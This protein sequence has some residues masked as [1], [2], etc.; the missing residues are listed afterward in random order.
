MCFTN[1][2]KFPEKGFAQLYIFWPLSWEDE[3][4][5]MDILFKGNRD[6]LGVQGLR[7]GAPSAGGPGSITG[8]ELDSTC[9]N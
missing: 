8:L 5:N 6:S 7:L 9:S 3:K 4:S 2:Y 1:M